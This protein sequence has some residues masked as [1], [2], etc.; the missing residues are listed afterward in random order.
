LYSLGG[1]WVL[2]GVCLA[3][4]TWYLAWRFQRSLRKSRSDEFL[5][6][7]MGRIAQAAG[8]TNWPEVVLLDG[9]FS[10]MLWGMGR[11]ARLV[12]PAELAARLDRAASDTLLL[13]ELA[14]YSRGDHWIRLLELAAKM[15]F[16]WH[17]VVW[18]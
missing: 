11:R 4:R 14:H 3:T 10:P 7:R 13:H 15:V 2:G 1:V 16:W 9:V 17:P 8:F 6:I 5:N 12:F 18:I